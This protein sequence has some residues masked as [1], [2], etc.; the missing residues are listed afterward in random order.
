MAAPLHTN[1]LVDDRIVRHVVSGRQVHRPLT[2]A[3]RKAVARRMR[4]LRAE[5][6]AIGAQL[7]VTPSA[8]A[9]FLATEVHR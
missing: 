3:E 2:I 5:P 9:A 8:V 1:Q 6:V 4:Q 7:G